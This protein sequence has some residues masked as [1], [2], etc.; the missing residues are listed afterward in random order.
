MRNDFAMVICI[1]DPSSG[2]FLPSALFPSVEPEHRSYTLPS[3]SPFE[4]LQAHTTA[5]PFV[6]AGGFGE[7]PGDDGLLGSFFFSVNGKVYSSGSS[8]SLRRSRQLKVISTVSYSYTYGSF[9]AI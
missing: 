8:S 3:T 4:L 7:R 6:V 1:V 9:Q 2:P 5:A